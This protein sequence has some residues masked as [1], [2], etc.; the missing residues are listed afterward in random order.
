MEENKANKPEYI[1]NQTN[2]NCQQFFGPVSGCVFAMAGSTVNM[3]S[4]NKVPSQDAEKRVQAVYKSRLCE[5]KADWGIVFK[6]LV[7]DRV[8]QAKDICAGTKFINTCC[9]TNVTTEDAISRSPAMSNL[10][11]SYR[12]GWSARETNR[13]TAGKLL[14]Y[15]TIAK[16]YYIG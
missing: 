1:E 16:T 12:T 6:L 8:F 4:E 9:G 7:E 2:N 5:S 3:P 10:A 11:G 14:L 13:E 15:N